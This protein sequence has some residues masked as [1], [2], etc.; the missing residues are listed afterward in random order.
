MLKQVLEQ[1]PDG[2]HTNEIRQVVEARL[3]R[4]ISKST[5]NDRLVRNSSFERIGRGKYRLRRQ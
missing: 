3:R 2:L 1:H 4:S 5:I